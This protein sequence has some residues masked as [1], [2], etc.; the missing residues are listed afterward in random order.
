MKPTVIAEKMVPSRT[1][2]RW[3]MNTNAKM[4]PIITIV[5]SKNGL[6]LPQSLF[7]T[8]PIA[9]TEPSPGSMVMSDFTSMTRPNARTRQ[10]IISKIH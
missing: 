6:T 7:S 4:T 8:S 1:P 10:L 2:S 3:P 5:T 9:T